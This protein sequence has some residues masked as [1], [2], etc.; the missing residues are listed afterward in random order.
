MTGFTSAIKTLLHIK[1]IVNNNY[2]HKNR[3][4]RYLTGFLIHVRGV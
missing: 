2:F 1:E 3:Y 4:L